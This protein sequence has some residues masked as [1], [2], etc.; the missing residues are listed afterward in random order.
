MDGLRWRC[1]RAG[2]LCFQGAPVRPENYSTWL[3][4]T[5]CVLSQKDWNTVQRLLDAGARV[6]SHLAQNMIQC[7]CT[8]GESGCSCDLRPCLCI[9]AAHCSSVPYAWMPHSSSLQPPT[10]ECKGQRERP[11][12]SVVGVILR[13]GVSCQGASIQR[14]RGPLHIPHNMSSHI[15]APIRRT[16]VIRKVCLR[17]PPPPQVELRGTDGSTALSCAQQGGHSEVVELL[18]KVTMRCSTPTAHYPLTTLAVCWYRP[19]PMLPR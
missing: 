14:R 1:T 9:Q 17:L 12:S 13:R 4:V 18:Q 11:H 6:T 2:S 10:G 19:R 7:I 8:Y 15:R 5:S 16:R 3:Y